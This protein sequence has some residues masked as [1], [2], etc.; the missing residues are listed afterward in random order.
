[1]IYRRLLLFPYDLWGASGAGE[2][3]EPEGSEGGLAL[4]KPPWR[5]WA[6][7]KTVTET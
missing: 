2:G 6:R 7:I 4:V 5:N 1:M 3:E